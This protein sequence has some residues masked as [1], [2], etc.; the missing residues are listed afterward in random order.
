M[1]TIKKN[2]VTKKWVK[3]SRNIELF[4]SWKRRKF[5][6]LGQLYTLNTLSISRFIYFAMIIVS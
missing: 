5:S 4:K 3:I 1:T 6:K 2:A